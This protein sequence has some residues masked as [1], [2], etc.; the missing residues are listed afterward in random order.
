MTIGAML[1]ATCTASSAATKMATATKDKP[2]NGI[3]MKDLKGIQEI[4]TKL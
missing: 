2:S 3:F 4:T 1:A